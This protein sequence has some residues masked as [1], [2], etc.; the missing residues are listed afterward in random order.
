MCIDYRELNRVTIKNKYPLPRIDDL[1]DQ[2]Q[3][4]SIFSKIDLRSGYYQLK[5]KEVDI[6]KTAFRTRY[7]HVIS[8]E[9]ISVDPQK[10]SAI[11]E[12]ARPTSVTEIRSFLGMTDYYLKISRHYLYGV[13]CEVYTEHQRVKYIFT[14]KELNLRHRRWLEVDETTEK[15]K[16]IREKL[17]TVQDRQ[18][19]YYDARH[20]KIEF[21]VRD[22]VF[23]K[24]SSMKGVMQ[25]GKASKLKPRYIGP[26]P[27][28]KRVGAVVYRLMLPSEMEKIHDIFHISMLRK[29]VP[30]PAQVVQFDP[31]QMKI[32][33]NLSYKEEPIKILARDVRRLRNKEIPMIKVIWNNQIEKEATWESENEMK[34]FYPDL[35]A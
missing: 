28:I 11:T 19:K 24:V 13:K 29:Y 16:F 5:I 20:K 2:L 21:E 30:D 27:I 12:W 8:V 25:F 9:G 22:Q 7:G 35:F 14:Q 15:I 31:K 18:K 3:G 33:P 17:C 34:K 10:V 32:K 26:F 23:L 1:F 6:S 4:D